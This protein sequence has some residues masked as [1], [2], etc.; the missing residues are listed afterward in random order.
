[1]VH[2]MFSF[3]FNFCLFLDGKSLIHFI[4]IVIT[5]MLFFIL[6][7]LNLCQHIMYVYFIN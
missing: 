3:R 7:C 1:M 5:F 2:L 4:D 6:F